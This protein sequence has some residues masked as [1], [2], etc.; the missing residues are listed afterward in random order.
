MN[1]APDTS[2]LKS[3]SKIT[4]EDSSEPNQLWTEAKQTASRL[5]DQAGE[6]LKSELDS[7][8][9]LAADTASDVASALRGTGGKLKDAG[10]LPELADQAADQIERLAQYVQSRNVGDLV[11]EVERFARRE[12]ALFLGASFAL[13]LLGGRFL[14]ASGPRS[15]A[16]GEGE[17]LDAPFE[18]ALE[19]GRS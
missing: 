12:P 2:R 4:L 17:Q 1:G 3:Q 5:A 8:K 19:G 11:R 13:G 16:P 6:K 9:D 15:S 14:K 7:R 18:L 10:P